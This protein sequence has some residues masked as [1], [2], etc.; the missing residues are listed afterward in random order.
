MT[1]TVNGIE[2]LWSQLDRG[3]NGTHVIVS[4]KHL[5]KYA[6][7]SEY[8][9]NRSNCGESMLSERLTTFRKVKWKEPVWHLSG[10]S[11]FY[12]PAIIAGARLI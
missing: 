4:G 6:R 2:G 3:I 1:A 11:V 8:R 10:V 9:F 12:K 7:E 5:E